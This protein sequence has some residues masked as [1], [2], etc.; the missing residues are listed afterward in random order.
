MLVAPG[1]EFLSSDGVGGGVHA[2]TEA[3]QVAADAAVLSVH[4]GGVQE[5]CVLVHLLT[6][7]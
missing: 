5:S 3:S 1:Q 7:T 4:H 2:A 6:G